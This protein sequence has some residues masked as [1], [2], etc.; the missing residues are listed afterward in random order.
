LLA[1][2]P[3]IPQQNVIYFIVLPS[4]VYKRFTTKMVCENLNVQLQGQRVKESVN[5]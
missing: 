3:F 2:S 5:W 4:L 1:L